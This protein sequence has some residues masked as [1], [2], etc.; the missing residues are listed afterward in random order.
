MSYDDDITW[1][2]TLVGEPFPASNRRASIRLNTQI[3][4]QMPCVRE[5]AGHEEHPTRIVF[6]KDALLGAEIGV[7]GTAY[8]HRVYDGHT[9]KLKAED[10]TEEETLGQFTIS[11]EYGTLSTDFCKVC[12]GLVRVHE[13]VNVDGEM[14]PLVYCQLGHGEVQT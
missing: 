1:P 11:D 12:G 5:M 13:L 14:R 8:L 6:A 9:F 4:F 10:Y 7:D 3:G 2:A